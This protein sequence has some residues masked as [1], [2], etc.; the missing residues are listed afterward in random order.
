MATDDDGSGFDPKSQRITWIPV[1]NICVVWAQSQRPLDPKFARQIAD[2]F[3]NEMFGTIAVTLPNGDGVYHAI[4]GHH[5]KAAVEMLWGKDEKVPCQVYNAH[6]P[7]RAA[8]IFD[9]INSVRKPVRPVDLFNVRVTARNDAEVA[10][11]RVVHANGY[12]ITSS[13]SSRSISAVAALLAVYQS[14]GEETLDATLKIIQATW[15]LDP[16]AV[17]AHILRG[18]GEFMSEHGRKA[19]WQRL[20]DNIAKKF[21][22][23]QL[24]ATARTAREVNGGSIPSNIKRVLVVQYNRGLAN[25]K[26]LVSADDVEPQPKARARSKSKSRNSAAELK[27]FLKD[28]AEKSAAH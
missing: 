2:N 18:Y 27:Q 14:Y 4:D 7:A 15:G 25:H 22:P 5:R 24:V 1:K 28:R 13:I 26:H 21:T 6:D 23:G 16:N 12:H 9:T 3:D 20:K 11:D 8:E 17:T 19:T 10:V